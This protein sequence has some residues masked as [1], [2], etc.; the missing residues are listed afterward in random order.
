M[1]SLLLATTIV[2]PSLNSF[3]K[4]AHAAL[5]TGVWISGCPKISMI[6]LIIW[7]FADECIDEE[8]HGHGE[9]G[10]QDFVHEV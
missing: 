4:T 7:L 5:V 10:E 3:T 1:Y 9:E 6:L 2:P 8:D